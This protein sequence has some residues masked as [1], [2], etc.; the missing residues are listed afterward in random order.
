MIRYIDTGKNG[1]GDS[2]GRWLDSEL[3]AG[4]RSFR[5]QFGFFDGAALRPFMPALRGI[6]EN[7]GT[8]RL[9]IGANTGDPPTTDDLAAILPLLG[10][11]ERTS[12]TVVA[13]SGALFHP[14]TMH[15]ERADGSKVGVVGSANF[16]R[17][18]LGHSVEAGLILESVAGT[19]ATVRE[20]ADAVDRWATATDAG[21]HQVRT[22]ADVDLLL[23]H[24]LAVTAAARRVIRSHQRGGTTT[25]GRGTRPV[26]WRPPQAALESPESEPEE[27]AEPIEPEDSSPATTSGLVLLWQSKPLTRRDLTLPSGAATNQT[28]SV[29]LDKGL[30]A[31]H[32][33]HRH[34]FRD[35]VFEYLRWE[36]RSLTVD[37]SFGKFELRIDGVSLGVFDLP[38]RHSTSTTSKTYLQRN[39]MTRLSW[40]PM[41]AHIARP[42][43]IGRTLSVFRRDSDPTKFVLTIAQVSDV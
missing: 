33:D 39:A 42:E 40:G 24:G 16:T 25:T 22:S 18:G 32:I 7:G 3:V 23:S 35:E 27:A 8:L 26:G 5:G 29:N 36:T 37:E 13:L 41:R 10:S 4:V 17:K 43:L 28:G 21:V 34:Y 20:I 31:E 6:A 12:L 30:L 19:G 9:V 2:L 15:I 38:I 14:K 11:F 1:T